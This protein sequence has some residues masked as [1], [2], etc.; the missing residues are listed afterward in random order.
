MEINNLTE[1]INYNNINTLCNTIIPCADVI[2]INQ[3]KKLED[4]KWFGNVIW[5][6]GS[7]YTGGFRGKQ[8]HGFGMYNF[9]NGQSLEC[10]W[11]NDKPKL[12]IED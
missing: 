1:G 4:D 3:E 9:P 2:C 8:K 12:D 6:D 10:I 11:E 7:Y 5:D